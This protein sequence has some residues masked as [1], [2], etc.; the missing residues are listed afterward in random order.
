[1]PDQNLNM[2]WCIILHRNQFRRN[3]RLSNQLG[4]KNRLQPYCS[5]NINI[6]QLSW[7]W[8]IK[9]KKFIGLK[10]NPHIANYSKKGEKIVFIYCSL[11]INRKQPSI[12]VKTLLF[13]RS[14]NVDAF[15]QT[16]YAWL[17]T[18]DFWKPWTLELHQCLFV[19]NKC[20]FLE[21]L[22]ILGM[23]IHIAFWPK[24][25]ICLNWWRVFSTL[26]TF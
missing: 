1:M 22:E 18:A 2:I 25:I 17:P 6:G 5:S 15:D 7:C 14:C 11:G 4:N 20:L 24:N 16:F 3:K 10:S 19:Y 9:N 8:N 26:I 12:I 21:P 23:M 13:S